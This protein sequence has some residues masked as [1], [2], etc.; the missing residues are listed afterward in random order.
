MQNKKIKKYMRFSRMSIAN[1]R[2]IGNDTKDFVFQPNKNVVILLGDNG[3]GKTT[4]LDALATSMA[5]YSAQFP[6]MSDYQLSELDVHI[7]R[8]GRRA[9]YLKIEAVL[10]DN[11]RRFSV[12]RYRKG[13]SV[14]PKS[15]FDQLKNEALATKN[16]IVAG[17]EDVEL[18]IFAYYGTGR[19]QFEVPARKR[20]F[21][22]SYERWDCYKS[23]LTPATD[24]KRFFGWF[25]LMED[26]ERRAKEKLQDWHYRL[27]VLEAVR[28]AL[29]NFI[30]SFRNPRIE[31][32]PLR[33]VMD[34]VDADGSSHELRIE[35][36]SDGYKI[37]MAMVADLAAR[38]AEA[39]PVLENP[40]E[41]KGIVLIDEVDLHLHPQWQRR[42]LKQLHQT[43]PN[44]QFVVSTHSPIIV[45]GAASIAQVINL[46]A[47]VEVGGSD[48]DVES[49]SQILL[50]DLFGLPS[51]H[52][53]EWDDK[54]A[55]RDKLLARTRL[56]PE[57]SERLVSLN[58]ELS[59]LSAI[60]SADAIRSKRLLEEI[61]ANLNIKL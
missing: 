8:H 52:G 51:L 10:M 12:A 22:Q 3:Y 47:N 55:E 16:A 53:P 28:T 1:F 30:E 29:S 17:V 50:G 45:V 49:I 35:Q 21:A 43:F 7:N 60:P 33:F 15:N 40:L 57:E 32:R 37:V 56:M 4:V 13:L 34:R 2:L 39:N 9:D 42:I 25:D 5:P 11:D 44:V 26:E 23:A 19:G 6:G 18:P 20:G 14:P 36:M 27:P 46:N 59:I 61:A 48:V 38:M 31:T 54:I 41:G 58:K 24:F